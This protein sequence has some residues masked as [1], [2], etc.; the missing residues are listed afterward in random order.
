A[1]A[2]DHDG[3][4]RTRVSRGNARLAK[5]DPEFRAAGRATQLLPRRGERC[6]A[7]RTGDARI[8]RAARCRMNS[9]HVG[10]GAFLATLTLATVAASADAAEYPT[11]PIRYVV[12]FAPG[13][14][15]DILARIV[16]QKLTEN[17]G[18]PV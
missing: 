1:Y 2:R 10:F 9:G 14:I 8:H 6:G 12:A 17:W 3:A 7:L 5:D 11:R 4:K 18:Q 13:G 16:G 15:N